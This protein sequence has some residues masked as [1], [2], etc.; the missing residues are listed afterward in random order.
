MSSLTDRQQNEN[1]PA[2]LFGE[3]ARNVVKK[4]NGKRSKNTWRDAYF[5]PALQAVRDSR[6]MGAAGRASVTTYSPTASHTP[7]PY[8][9]SATANTIP[10]TLPSTYSRFL[11]RYGGDPSSWPRKHRTPAEWRDLSVMFKAIY[12]HHAAASLGTVHAFTLNLRP[13]VEVLIRKRPSAANEMLR[14]ISRELAKTFPG[15]ESAF[16]FA[17][18]TTDHRRLHLHGEIVTDDPELARKALRLAGGEWEETRQHQAHTR[19][20]PDEGWV[21][22]ALTLF[23][24][25]RKHRLLA[26]R[27]FN[28]NP[29]ACTRNLTR[30]AET[31]YSADRAEVL[32]AL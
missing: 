12:W 7:T 9:C 24:L 14:R 26:S 29:F 19:A 16:W 1:V 8:T 13:D 11:R 6:A 20:E 10:S 30:L 3:D 21:S 27:G 28:G 31:L 2:E 18:E 4:V 22:Y 32:L 23:G 15:H 17:L 5:F 25:H